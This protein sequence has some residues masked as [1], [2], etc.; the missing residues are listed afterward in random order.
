MPT[1]TK[2]A[3]D[4]RRGDVILAINGTN[5][6]TAIVLDVTRIAANVRVRCW[7]CD[8]KRAVSQDLPAGADLRLE[9]EALTPAQE[10]ADQLAD[11]LRQAV[12]GRAG[13]IEPAR[14]LLEE[15]SPQPPTAR[16]LAGAL[17]IMGPALD[18]GR[19]AEDVAERA[20]KVRA[21]IERARRAG[22][23]P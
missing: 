9:A 22:L 12:Q 10:H 15:V 21:M 5:V 23:L 19:P 17:L 13:W 6:Q 14:V 3:A 20:A 7:D 16:E 18:P 2:K 1:V 11:L 8:D 4:V